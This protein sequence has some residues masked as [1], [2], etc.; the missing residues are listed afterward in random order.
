MK[1]YRFIK[2][3]SIRHSREVVMSHIAKLKPLKYNQFR[4]WRTHT[5]NI[6]PL[7]KRAPLK[8]RI[9]NG[10]FNPSSYLWQA[11][12]ALYTA[13][14][15]LDPRKDNSQSQIEKLQVDMARYKKLMEDYEKEETERYNSLIEAFTSAFKLTK[16]QLE[17]EFLDWPGDILSF[18]NYA[19]SF[20]NTSPAE[21]RKTGKRGRPKKQII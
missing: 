11:Q 20:L 8:D 3:D 15:K 7:G 6:T 19:V 4:W 16:E 9:I 5:D 12:L 18:Y 10:D 21:N 17:N 2:E 1:G 14:D 13:K